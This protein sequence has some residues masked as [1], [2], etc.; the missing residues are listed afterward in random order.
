LQLGYCAGKSSRFPSIA[1]EARILSPTFL[2]IAT[3]IVRTPNRQPPG[4]GQA[5]AYPPLAGLRFRAVRPTSASRRIGYPNYGTIAGIHS[6][7][8]GEP[9]SE[10]IA[11]RSWKRSS[12]S[13]RPATLPSSPFATC[14]GLVRIVRAQ[15]QQGASVGPTWCPFQDEG[16]KDRPAPSRRVPRSDS[17]IIRLV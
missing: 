1:A 16:A 2:A 7:R 14:P 6:H 5:P 13:G 17:T 8:A 12:E 9:E 10:V 11:R 4:P 15:P 3:R